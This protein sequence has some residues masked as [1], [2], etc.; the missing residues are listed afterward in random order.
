V[1]FMQANLVVCRAHVFIRQ[2][3]ISDLAG[4]DKIG[5]QCKQDLKPP[6]IVLVECVPRDMRRFEIILQHFLL[7]MPSR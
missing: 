4:L 7:V 3:P 6:L 2:F 5:G 1:I